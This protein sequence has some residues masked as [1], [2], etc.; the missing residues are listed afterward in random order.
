MNAWQ[1]ARQIKYL[2]Q[3]AT[4]ADAPHG[5]V[6]GSVRITQGI[7]Q[8]EAMGQV[9]FPAAF[10]ALQ[11]SESDGAS[12]GLKMQ[13][14]QVTIVVANQGDIVGEAAMIGG[15]RSSVGYSGGRGLLEVEEALLNV[16]NLAD[17][18]SGL[19]V[20][21]VASSAPEAAFAE[22]Y[23]YVAERR[24]IFSST[25]TTGRSYPAPNGSNALTTS[26][27]ANSG[28]LKSVAVSW[29]AVEPRFDLHAA[30]AVPL[31]SAVGK[32]L[33]VRKAGTSAPTTPA[34]GTALTLASSYATGYADSLTTSSGSYTYGLFAQFDEFGDAVTSLR[35]SAPAVATVSV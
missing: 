29:S 26:V 12:P 6:F 30:V 32:L 5:P 3:N 4:W 19:N 22:E 10:V 16:L 23:G 34:D 27:G 7:G 14:W 31:I 24:F 13:R 1:A 28:G 21:L 9:R 8:D 15:Q 25:L 17:E 20:L 2:V 18:T 11:D 33:L 35:L